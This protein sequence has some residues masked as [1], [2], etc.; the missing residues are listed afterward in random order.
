MSAANRGAVVRREMV[1]LAEQVRHLPGATVLGAA[2]V[3][4]LCAWIDLLDHELG[5]G[6]RILTAR[7]QAWR[8][9]LAP[10][11]NRADAKGNAVKMI[12]L[13]NFEHELDLST[14]AGILEMKADTLRAKLRRGDIQ[15]RKV[16]QQWMVP[17]SAIQEEFRKGGA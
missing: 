5:K 9:V 10:G 12:D 3:T 7:L 15:G 6:S 13:L 14:A 8:A 2:R 17:L 11:C 16:G 1:E 4:E